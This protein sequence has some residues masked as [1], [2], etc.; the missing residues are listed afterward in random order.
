MESYS[1]ENVGGMMERVKK[2]VLRDIERA[3]S[4]FTGKVEPIL[5]MRHQI[6]EAD[7]AYYDKRF[8]QTAGQSDFVSFDFWSMV[9]WAIPVIMNSFFGGDE[10]VVIVGRNEEDVPRAELLKSLIQFQLMTQ[11]KGFLVLWDWF[12]D[13]F[14]YN[15]GAV[16]IWWE[17]VEDWD[18]VKIEYADMTRLM[19]IQGDPNCEIE[20]ASSPDMFGMCQVQ[21]RVGRLKSNKPV[22]EPVRVTDLRWS[23]EAK[24]LEDANFVA[25]R[26]MVTADHLRKQARAGVYDAQAVERAIENAN[27]GSVIYGQFEQELNDELDQR[28]ND[29]DGARALYELY[30][31]YV[32][33]DINGDG[34]LEDALISVVGDELIRVTENPY[35]RVPIFTLSPIRDPFK[36]MGSLSLAEIVGEIQTIKT[37]LMRQMLI[38][39]VITNNFRWFIDGSGVD[40]KD[41]QKN[42]QY[43]KVNGDPRLKVLPFP[44][45]AIAP[46]SMTLYEALEGALEQYTGKTRYNQGTDGSSLNKT[47]TGI[48]L[49]QQ[50]SEQR[51]DYIVRVFAETGVS[52][53]LRFMVELNQRYIDQPTVIRLKNQ[54][55]PISPDDLRG[56]FDIDVNTEAGIARK[57]QTIQNLQYYMTVIAPTGMNIGAVTPVE[58]S[59][60]AQKLL[61]ES[62]IR[63]PQSYVVSPEI[64]QQ[65]M[66]MAQQAQQA[67][68]AAQMQLQGAGAVREAAQAGH[69][70]GRADAEA[71]SRA[72]NGGK[73]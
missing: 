23:P 21:Y 7:R 12:T 62:G 65:Q 52:E 3:N 32:K 70:A 41:I 40:L 66:M 56:D 60:A 45:N 73:Q 36:V 20:Y 44:Q 2:S 1:W 19:M 6:Y 57:S 14:Q 22:I 18:N 10:A 37:A 30:E 59:K 26:Q 16:K 71:I 49:L 53:L 35:G 8:S 5:R 50:A 15:L 13:A 69:E 48:S 17:R 39:T 4:F 43:I 67:M 9:Q 51:I 47:A 25:H 64:L 28:P 54:M 29:E 24:S 34:M 46:W 63:D 68:Q 31:C 58:W 55:L 33:V 11:N 42:R 38:N 27:S 61:S 72:V